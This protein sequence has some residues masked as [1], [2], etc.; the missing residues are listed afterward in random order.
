MYKKYIKDQNIIN[1]LE[2]INE[3]KYNLKKIIE[4]ND[5]RIDPFIVELAGMPRTGKTVCLEKILEFFL[6]GN[7]R[8]KK[9]KEPAQILK[10]KYDTTKFSNLEFND[11]TLEISRYELNN[12]IADN[13]SII[14]QDRGVF[15]NY[16]WYQMMYEKGEIDLNTYKSRFKQLKNDL[17]MIDKLYLMVADP[18]II[19]E[20]DYINQIY[21]EERK[22]TTI[23]G[24]KELK[25]GMND[26]IETIDNDCFRY[27]DTSYLSEI[28][29][30]IYITDDILDGMTKKLVKK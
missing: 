27:V 12:C 25:N 28:N 1:K 16:I 9:T 19:V 23:E 22:K 10:E 6:K 30:A 21:L 2:Y 7:F 26:L 13:P 11:K 4:E 20:R 17:E 14:L 5:G 8:V 15:D 3:K 29:T 24:V 18:N